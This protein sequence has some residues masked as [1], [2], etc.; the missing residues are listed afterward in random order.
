[1]SK[2]LILLFLS[3]FKDTAAKLDYESPS[4]DKY[5]GTQTNDAP[6]RYLID[7]AEKDGC[8]IENVLCIVSDKVL[9]E[10]A[11]A[12]GM[13]AYDRFKDFISLIEKAR[14][15]NII[16]GYINAENSNKES[17]PH[18]I[19]EQIASKMD[20]I[21][22]ESVYID[23][24]GGF[25]DL[26]FLMT[27]IIGFMEFRGIKC[28]Q[29]VYSNYFSKRIFDITYIFNM[30]RMINAVSEFAST[31]NA[32]SINRFYQENDDKDRKIDSKVE[33]LIENMVRFSDMLSLCKV[34]GIDDVLKNIA[35]NIGEIEKEKNDSHNELCD[36]G[37]LDENAIY[38]SMMKSL[39]SPIRDKMHMGNYQSGSGDLEV[40]DYPSIISWCAENGL[41]QQAIVLYVE[42]IPLWLCEKKYVN[43]D[44][45][46]KE[47]IAVKFYESI[48][49]CDNADERK[50]E[51]IR[52]IADKLS[53]L[54]FNII[55]NEE[56]QA[57][58][59]GYR[60]DAGNILDQEYSEVCKR[61]ENVFLYYKNRSQQ[62]PLEIYGEKIE[63]KNMNKFLTVVKNGTGT[64][65]IH[66]LL[67]G[68]KKKPGE[69]E[70]GYRNAY[71]RKWT[72]I[73]DMERSPFFD[74]SINVNEQRSVLKYYLVLKIVRNML[75]HAGEDERD[76]SRDSVV[77]KMEKEGLLEGFLEGEG[78]EKTVV[79]NVSKLK[80]LLE[81]TVR[82]V[83]NLAK[84]T[85]ND[86]LF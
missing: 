76:E 8:N 44:K 60:N 73:N 68:D 45:N 16:V 59:T 3:D 56:L 48:D 25:R 67:Y 28:A 12:I 65:Y 71:I 38:D 21:K 10:S 64:R 58:L 33:N 37:Y 50:K 74:E 2:G 39:I 61:I 53:E 86:C 47:N 17:S 41:I 63:P 36:G 70:S 82:A 66:Y 30:N 9:T 14:G 43:L 11:G 80:K 51:D 81:Q 31:G 55:D 20:E 54:N 57:Y 78:D 26:S 42:K 52:K 49:K 69:E 19:Y 84:K 62:K 85:N 18:M 79:L 23:Y 83:R 5:P 7:K 27:T 77:E 72:A 75:S 35:Q 24:T 22:P 13:S 29:V 4:G 40:P 1:M 46:E 34:D 32:G 6:V 15:E